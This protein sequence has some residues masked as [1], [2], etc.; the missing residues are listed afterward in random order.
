MNDLKE[1]F[2]KFD[3]QSKGHLSVRELGACCRCFG[4]VATEA[5]RVKPFQKARQR[6]QMAMNVKIPP[7]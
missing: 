1:A 4:Y 6:I 3:A 5:V 7:C 2:E